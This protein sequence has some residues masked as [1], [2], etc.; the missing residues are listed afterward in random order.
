M[1]SKITVAITFLFLVV[2]LSSQA[3]QLDATFGVSGVTAPPSSDATGDH[4]FQ[5]VGG[6]TYLGFSGDYLFFHNLGVN[7]EV[8]WRAGRNIYAVSQQPFRPIFFDFNGIW[9]PR[10]SERV[11]PELKAGLGVESVRFYQPFF[12]CQSFFGGCTDYTSTNHFMGDFGAAVRLYVWNH[13]FVRPEAQVYLIHNNVEF[14]S[15]HAARFG[16]SIG[17]TFRSEY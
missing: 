7:G 13:V 14:S 16:I 15:G 12:I 4:A 8:N 11:Q 17:Y 9:V 5:T 6:G 10:V 1:R 2:A 3:Q